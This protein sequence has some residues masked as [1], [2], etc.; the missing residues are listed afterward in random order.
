V[1]ADWADHLAGRL[2]PLKNPFVIQGAAV[3]QQVIDEMRS[4][5]TR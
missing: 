2:T 1:R 3:P 4:R 5:W